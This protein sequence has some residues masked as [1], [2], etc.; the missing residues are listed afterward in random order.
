MTRRAIAVPDKYLVEYLAKQASLIRSRVRLFC[1]LTLAIFAAVSLISYVMT[2]DEFKP[3]E[4]LVWLAV[5]LG[6][7]AAFYLS[8]RTGT[9]A[10]AKLNAYFFTAILVLCLSFLCGL[11]YSY[12]AIVPS[13]YLF[14]LVMVAF[15]IPWNPAD[16][17]PLALMHIGAYA[18]VFGYVKSRHALPGLLDDLTRTRFV[19]GVTL[20]LM[21]A[22][23]SFVVRRKEAARDAEN[24]VLLKEVEEKNA[25][26]RRE[27]ELATR[28][29]KTLI[30]HSV[31]TDMVDVAVMYLP[32]YYIGGDYAKFHVIDKDRL[33]FIICDVTG[34]GVSAALLVN[35]IHAEVE[36]LAREGKG[37][38]VLLKE[39]DDFITGDFGGINMFLS[40]FC[41]VL[42]FAKMKLDY[43]NHGHPDQYIYRITRS[44]IRPLRSQ[45][46]LLGLPHADEGICQH[47]V[48]F[49]RG[50]KLFLFTDGVLETRDAGGACYDETRLEAF[51]REHSA[52]GAGAF[53]KAL[54]DDLNAFKGAAF[55]D[56]IFILSIDIKQ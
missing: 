1:V 17:V 44:E 9:P 26:M 29:H 10:A 31:S 15:T 28:I 50:D 55:T 34:H 5:F 20:I 47:S 53:N 56:D 46:S 19:D 4:T 7:F 41:G 6:G 30:P 13:L 39:L 32:M 22:V 25:Q 21:G 14:L 49:S 8:G 38:G 11:Y 23:L 2:P 35:R 52:L 51:I 24:F 36:R 27:L 3:A 42:D 43:S 45:A 12:I 54:V 37:P 18:L 33:L 16:I 48:D 40:A